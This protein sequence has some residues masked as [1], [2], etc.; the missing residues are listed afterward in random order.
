[1]HSSTFDWTE[2]HPHAVTVCDVNG[3]IIALNRPAQENFRKNGGADLIGQSL[4]ACHPEPANALIRQLLQE[5]KANS[6]FVEKNGKKIL[7]QQS[8]WFDQGEFAGLVETIIPLPEEMPTKKR[9]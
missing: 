8:P 7:V 9:P 5:Q 1:M 6:Y 3:I 4:F 2:H